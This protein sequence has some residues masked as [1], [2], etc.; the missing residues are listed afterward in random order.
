M[1]DE[2][3]E[4]CQRTVKHLFEM[5]KQCCVEKLCDTN[6]GFIKSFEK[7]SPTELRPYV[8]GEE[9]LKFKQDETVSFDTLV[10]EIRSLMNESIRVSWIDFTLYY[11]LKDKTY[12]LANVISTDREVETEYHLG[13]PMTLG[14]NPK[15][16]RLN[17]FVDEREKRRHEIG[18]S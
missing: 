15:C 6:V 11:S 9:Y 14:C 5:A 7:K 8:N 4:N 16:F 17:D 13:I 10:S 3:Y 18:K 1:K 12:V 2:L